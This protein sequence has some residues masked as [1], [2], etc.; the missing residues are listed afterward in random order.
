MIF[1]FDRLWLTIPLVRSFALNLQ[2]CSIAG[3]FGGG[4][5]VSAA[6]DG[7][8]LSAGPSDC[9]MP[10]QNAVNLFQQSRQN[11]GRVAL[12]YDLQAFVQRLLF[13]RR[14]SSSHDCRRP[15]HAA[16]TANQCRNTVLVQGCHGVNRKVEKDRG[17]SGSVNQRYPV[18]NQFMG[19]LKGRFFDCQLNDGFDAIIKDL[20]KIPTIAG[21]TD[22]EWIRFDLMHGHLLAGP[23][24]S[25]AILE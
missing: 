4:Q 23:I 21:V 5:D 8:L 6:G 17:V 22:P 9:L 1:P 2:S 3:A 13:D 20:S 7:P 11:V 14:Q 25:D 10:F 12:S 15:T 16:P 18:V 19:R 24:F